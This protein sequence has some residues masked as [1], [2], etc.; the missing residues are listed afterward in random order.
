MV[1]ELNIFLSS[2]ANEF[3]DE[4][5]QI[6]EEISK[7][8]YLECILQEDKGPLPRDPLSASLDDV[9]KCNILVGILGD[10]DSKTTR[11]E[12]DSAINLGKYCLIYVKESEARNEKM[13]MFIQELITYK[14]VYDEFENVTDL[15]S[16]VTSHLK[17]HIYRILNLGL[18][19]F[20]KE[21][22]KFMSKDE[23]AEA[24][25]RVKIEA[26]KYMPNK[27]LQDAE[28]SFRNG[29]Y[30][31]SVVEC[32]TLLE[33]AFKRWLIRTE[34][35]P[36]HEVQKQPIGRL[37]RMIHNK[38]VMDPTFFDYITGISM[39]RNKAVHGAKIPSEKDA[40][41]VMYWTRELLDKFGT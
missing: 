32:A 29:H 20:M 18:D 3:K 11:A 1:K 25:T 14:V 36:E 22:Q 28:A 5:K 17:E 37:V 41:T 40:K 8:P 16:N 7:I 21:R 12:I 31:A 19:A 23:S 33:N 30:L 35:L 38:V 4:R 15:H 6:S 13:D 34:V 9:E 39:V 10:C 24:E 27:I 26:G 2:N